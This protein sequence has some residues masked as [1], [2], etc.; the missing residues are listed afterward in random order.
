VVRAIRE[1]V[2]TAQRAATEARKLISQAERELD[3]H[4]KHMLAM[5]AQ[6]AA[7]AATKRAA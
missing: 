1:Q 2:G 3:V 6:H 4:R 7:D 5:E